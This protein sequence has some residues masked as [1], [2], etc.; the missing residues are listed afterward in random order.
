MDPFT[1]DSK[2][3]GEV[4]RKTYSRQWI[5][6]PDGSLIGANASVQSNIGRLVMVPKNTQPKYALP[7]VIRS[8]GLT[9]DFESK[10]R[11]VGD[12]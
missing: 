4:D 6:V 7:I 11:V 2:C 5:A 12:E 3:L 1:V 9:L 8:F 10:D